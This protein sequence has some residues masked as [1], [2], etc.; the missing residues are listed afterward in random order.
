MADETLR[1]AMAAAVRAV[2]KEG[3]R[4]AEDPVS[5]LRSAASEVRQLVTLFEQDVADADESNAAVRAI[6]A[7]EVEAAAEELIR[8][9]RH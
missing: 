1:K 7:E 5:Y 3:L 6:L 4:K 8:R 9:L 2:L